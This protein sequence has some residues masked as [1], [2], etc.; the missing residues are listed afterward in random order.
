MILGPILFSIFVNELDGGQR[1]LSAS[2]QMIQS[3][4][5]QLMLPDGCAAIQRNPE[6][7]E[8]SANKNLMQFIK[9]KLNGVRITPCTTGINAY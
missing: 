7:L 9:M 4:K 5:E 1:T 8:K 3:L 2:S 6:R